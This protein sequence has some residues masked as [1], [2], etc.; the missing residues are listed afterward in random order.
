M[1]DIITVKIDDAAAIAGS[2]MPPGT[3]DAVGLSEFLND[4]TNQSAILIQ[5]GKGEFSFSHRTF[6]EFF[7]AKAIVSMADQ[8]ALEFI[9]THYFQPRFEEI[10]R[11][12]LSWM[13]VHGG[14][15]ELVGRVAKELIDAAR[16]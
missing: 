15:R 11:L 10:I 9:T 1:K 6:Q 14:R 16:T 12:S 4:L 5:R 8:E 13:N 7:A 3:A 2:S